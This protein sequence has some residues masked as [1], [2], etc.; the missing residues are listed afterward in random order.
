[1]RHSILTAALPRQLLRLALL[2]GIALSPCYAVTNYRISL[3]NPD[4]HL[5]EVQIVLPEGA[6][7]RQLQLPVWNS[8]YQIREFSQYVNWIRAKNRAGRPLSIL[9]VDNSRWQIRGAQDG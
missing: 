5:V 1:M 3:A 7:E 6:Q 4:Q 8:L 2:L 9:Q